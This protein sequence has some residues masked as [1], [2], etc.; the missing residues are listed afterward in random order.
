[1][2][3]CFWAPHSVPLALLSLLSIPHGLGHGSFGGGLTLEVYILQHG[4]SPI[5]SFQITGLN[6]W[7]VV[8][9]VWGSGD[10]HFILFICLF[11]YSYDRPCGI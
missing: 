8:N 7:W 6:L 11:V 3:V 1:M 10:Q 5:Q 4:S 9:L 2:R